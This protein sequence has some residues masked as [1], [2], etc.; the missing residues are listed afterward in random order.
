MISHP[1][2][3]EGGSYMQL[4]RER[5]EDARIDA[6][7]ITDRVGEERGVNSAGQKIYSLFD[8]Y[9]HADL[10]TYPSSYEG[11]GNAFIEAVYFRKPVVVNTHTV[12]R[13]T[14]LRSVQTIEIR[15]SSATKLSNRP[16]NWT[17]KVLRDE[18]ASNYKLAKNIFLSRRLPQTRRPITNYS[19]GV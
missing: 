8:V 3:D 9:P 10:V 13:A 1:G 15:N 2:G 16:L 18:W 14:L 12:H 7:F 5:I 17:D 11:F 19:R 6:R 4:L